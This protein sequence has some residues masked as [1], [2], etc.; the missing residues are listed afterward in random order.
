MMDKIKVMVSREDGAPICAEAGERSIFLTE[1][2][3]ILIVRKDGGAVETVAG[4]I[5]TLLE[6][7]ARQLEGLSVQERRKLCEAYGLK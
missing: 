5:Q 7:T 6:F 4:G 2:S 3:P 1:Q